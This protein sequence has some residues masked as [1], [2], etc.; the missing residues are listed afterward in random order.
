MG[1]Q[2]TSFRSVLKTKKRDTLALTSV[3]STADPPVRSEI[4][5]FRACLA[6]PDQIST[7]ILRAI[8]LKAT[9]AAVRSTHPPE[10]T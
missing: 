5:K 9:D 1:K 4:F 6:G 3:D 7:F 2:N 8:N 10:T